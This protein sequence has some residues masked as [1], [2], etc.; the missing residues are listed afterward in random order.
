MAHHHHP[1]EDTHRIGLAFFLNLCFSIIEIIGGLYTNSVAILSDALHDLGDS[2]SLGL[3]WHFQKISHRE[4]DATYSY[5]YKRFS[6]LGAIINSV[7]LVIGSVFILRE[8]IPRLIQSEPTELKG[9]MLLALLGVV[10]NGYAVLKL[11]K[12]QSHN[13]KVVSL[14]LL[15]DVIGWVAVFIGSIIIYLTGWHQ[16]DPLLSILVTL[17][18]L[19][20]IYRNI[21]ST[22]RIVLQAIPEAIDL[23]EVTSSLKEIENIESFHDLH[24]WSLDGQRNIL[25]VHMV[26]ADEINYQRIQRIRTEVHQRMMELGIQHVTV[27]VEHK[28]MNC[29][30][31]D[32]E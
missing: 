22:L 23:Q 16:V 30:Q 11:N 31:L 24:I 1:H 17:F 14:H 26:T 7:V 21:T 5:G 32:C 9:M 13:E 27:E 29:T 25:T 28:E 6:V 10:V 15:E 3:A 4:G 19:F 20:N 2:L 18:I 8:A 12:G